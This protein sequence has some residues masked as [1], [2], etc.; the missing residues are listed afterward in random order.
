MASTRYKIFHIRVDHTEGYVR[1]ESE[2]TLISLLKQ[3]GVKDFTITRAPGKSRV[4]T[5]VYE[6]IRTS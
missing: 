3:Y 1:V 4:A 2:E 5:S 6:C